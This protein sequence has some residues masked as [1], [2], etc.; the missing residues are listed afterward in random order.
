MYRPPKHSLLFVVLLIVT[1]IACAPSSSTP[2][3]PTYWPTTGWR[4]AAPE[5]QGMDSEK[6]AQMVEHIQQEKLDLHSLLIVR[7]GY[8]VSELYAY[9]YS[10]GQAHWIM[11]VTK[12]VIDAL[13]G[14]AIQK[15]YIKDVHQ[16]LF[17]LLPDQGVA[18]LDEKKKAIT[19]EDF[20][21]MTSGLDCHENPAPGEPF[22]QA[23]AELGSIHAGSAH[24]RAAR[25]EVQ[26]LHGRRRGA[27]GDS[28]E[29]HRDDAPASLPTRTCSA[30]S[31]LDPSRKRAGRPIPRR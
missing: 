19:L 29:S 3:P 15:G 14:I 30:R 6:L 1:L 28:P 26:L 18:N 17:S 10:A 20:L 2:T 9:P 8:L 27:F 22:M 25:D 7:N 31:G 23:S 16:P 12:S 21:T 11:S 5:E 4:S 13:V 24:G